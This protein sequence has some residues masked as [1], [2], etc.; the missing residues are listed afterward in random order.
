[1]KVV[2]NLPKVALI[3][4]SMWCYYQGAMTFPL[5]FICLMVG[6]SLSLWGIQ[7]V[8]MADSLWRRRGS[9]SV[10]PSC[11]GAGGCTVWRFQSSVPPSPWSQQHWVEA[12]WRLQA[13]DR[14]TS[15]TSAVVSYSIS[16]NQ[17]IKCCKAIAAK[18]HENQYLLLLHMM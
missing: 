14:F 3:W 13:L 1:M 9:L 6:P 8:L 16:I 12:S 18:E 5:P 17:G 2:F 4:I 15:R 7:L 11:R 10:G